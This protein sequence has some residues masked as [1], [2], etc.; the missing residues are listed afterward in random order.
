MAQAVEDACAPHDA[1]PGFK[2]TRFG[3]DFDHS[4]V[5]QYGKPVAIHFGSGVDLDYTAE[6]CGKLRMPLI[7]GSTRLDKAGASLEALQ[8]QHNLV[9]VNAPNLSLPMI[10]FLQA[11]PGFAKAINPGMRFHIA[12]SHQIGKLDVSGTARAIAEKLGHEG[13]ITS[14]REQPDQVTLFGVPPEHLAG[15]AY[16]FFSFSG[17]GVEIRISTK[18]HGRRTYAEGALTLATALANPRPKIDQVLPG[19]YQVTDLLHLIPQ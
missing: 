4:N 12:E 15:H 7:Q 14:C 8:R 1:L 2:C 5:G 6:L 3:R 17:Q 9:V 18:I 11:F 13:K 16:H 10:R 19:L